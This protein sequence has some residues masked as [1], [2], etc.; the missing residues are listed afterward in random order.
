MKKPVM[1]IW[2]TANLD[3]ALRVVLNLEAKEENLRNFKVRKE[4]IERNFI[5]DMFNLRIKKIYGWLMVTSSSTLR[6][7]IIFLFAWLESTKCS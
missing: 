1:K 4:F 6:P 3:G 7:H 5:A 2:K